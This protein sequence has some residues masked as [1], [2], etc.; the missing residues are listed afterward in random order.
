MLYLD[1]E[2][3]KHYL[4]SKNSSKVIKNLD[5]NIQPLKQMGGDYILSSVPI[6]NANENS[7]QLQKVFNSK[8]AYWRIYLYKVI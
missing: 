8:D 6:K 5:L 3:G 1:S 7:L 2:L 4:F